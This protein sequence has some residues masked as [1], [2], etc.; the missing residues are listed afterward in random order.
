MQENNNLLNDIFFFFTMKINVFIERENKHLTLELPQN[1]TISDLL[2]KLKI[3]ATT[4]LTA[5]NEELTVGDAKLNN[6]DHIKIL[7]VISGG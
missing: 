1:A 3:N 4:V 2:K 6:N 5:K 7:S